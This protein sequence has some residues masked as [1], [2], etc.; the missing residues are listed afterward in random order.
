[1]SYDPN[2]MVRYQALAHIAFSKLTLPDII[3][4]VRDPNTNVRK[5]ALLILSEKVLIKFITIEKRLF[6]LKYSLKDDDISVV[7]TCTKRLLPSWLAF[8]ENDI[9]KLLKALDVVE[10]PEI[11]E[12]MLDK[13]NTETTMESLCNDFISYMNEKYLSYSEFIIFNII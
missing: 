2:W 8:K 3:D 12:L 13:L 11:M 7:D 1:M 10:A 4:R 9:V 6:I 5:K